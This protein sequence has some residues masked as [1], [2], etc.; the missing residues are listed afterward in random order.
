VANSGKNVGL[1]FETIEFSR[2]HKPGAYYLVR[3]GQLLRVP[4][5]GISKGR[6]PLISYC[7]TDPVLVHC[8]SDDPWVPIGAARKMVGALGQAVRF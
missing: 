6:G 8:L 4:E 3:T 5:D 2:I 1:A 7:S